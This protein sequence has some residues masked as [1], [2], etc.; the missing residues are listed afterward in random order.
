MVKQLH[1]LRLLRITP[2]GNVFVLATVLYDV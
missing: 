2:V 1:I